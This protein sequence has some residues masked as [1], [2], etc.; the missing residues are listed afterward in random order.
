MADGAGSLWFRRLRLP[1][2]AIF[3]ISL[4]IVTTTTTAATMLSIT[5]PHAHI[6]ADTDPAALL[7][8][9]AAEGGA[10]CQAG[11]LLRAVDCEVI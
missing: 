8:D 2:S 7:G 1:A 5:A 11:E 3:S 6:P 9:G 10:L 4:L